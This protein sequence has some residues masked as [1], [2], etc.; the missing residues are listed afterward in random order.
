MALLVPGLMVLMDGLF[1]GWSPIW[2]FGLE[3]LPDLILASYATWAVLGPVVVRRSQARAL[4]IG[5]ASP[6][7][8]AFFL[9]LLWAFLPGPLAYERGLWGHVQGLAGGMLYAV[10]YIVRTAPFTILMGILTALLLQWLLSSGRPW[11]KR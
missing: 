2:I 10:I 6:F 4:W 1:V 5:V 9:L 7:L 8:G 3:E 11:L